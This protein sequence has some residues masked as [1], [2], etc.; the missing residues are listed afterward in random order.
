MYNNKGKFL[1]Y[2]IS[3]ALVVSQILGGMLAC[4]ADTD[5]QAPTNPS[6]LTASNAT[7][8]SVTL[9]WTV[10][11]DNV[12]VVA[13]VLYKNN[14][15]LT[16][17]KRNST[18]LTGLRVG[19]TYTFSVKAV[20]AEGN[21]SGD[22]NVV[23]ITT[24]LFPVDVTVTPYETR[25][26]LS[27]LEPVVSAGT[28][29][30]KYET[31]LDGIR[32]A[33]DPRTANSLTGLDEGRVY[34]VKVKA[35]NTYGQAV[36][37]SQEIR[38]KTLT[39]LVEPVP[40]F[41]NGPTDLMESNVSTNSLRLTWNAPTDIPNI[42]GY[43][44]V[45]ND[46]MLGTSNKVTTATASLDVTGLDIGKTYF[47]KV[48]AF[49]IA[50][51]VSVYSNELRVTTLL[52]Q[53]AI[54]SNP[55]DTTVD[56]SWAAVTNATAYEIYFNNNFQGKTTKLANTITG[57][58]AGTLYVVNVKAVDSMGRY[59][60]EGTSNI[61][62]RQVITIVLTWDAQ[63]RDLDSYLVAPDG[64]YVYYGQREEYIDGQLAAQLA[65]DD[66]NGYGPEIITIYRQMSGMYNYFVNNYSGEIPLSQSGAIVKVYNG[67]DLT[68][69]FNVPTTGLGTSWTVFEMNSNLITPVNTIS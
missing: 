9:D 21:L 58:T 27:W 32:Q 30:G 68:N 28:T 43:N 14:V 5:T 16:R 34:L 62:T 44:V 38:V 35:L 60:A 6:N 37:E 63:P 67:S 36:A 31:Y 69:T 55:T 53:I 18:I 8:T 47:Y 48:Q 10:S 11:T 41:P 20:D 23:Q 24:P 2:L 1:K 3:G 33:T 61:I 52:P 13:Y 66:T 22:S 29:I 45:S 15:E 19:Q 54:V 56:L 51:N 25:I 7:P 39:T 26:D 57:L 59:I 49:D 4:F 17:P 46:T 40:V 65:Q 12:G 64:Y 50:G 42:A